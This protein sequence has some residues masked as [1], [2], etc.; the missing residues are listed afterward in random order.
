[1]QYREY[2]ETYLKEVAEISQ[3]VDRQ[4]IHNAIKL[5]KDLKEK[6]GRLFFLGI[7][8]SAANSSHA[9]NDFRKICKI[10]T[11]TPVD[12]VAELTAWTNDH[13]FEV[14]FSHWLQGSR[15]TKND[16]VMVFSVGGGSEKTSRNIVRALEYAKKVGSKIIGVVSKD[17]GMTKQLADV[18]ILIPVVHDKRITAH[19][20]EWQGVVWHLIVNALDEYHPS[21]P[22][23]DTKTT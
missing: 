12:N 21:D 4:A 15:L 1:M 8:G 14:I 3:K 9:V 18:V 22:Y 19:A 16:V 7:G 13:S 5:L 17:G 2:I 10:E 23:G 6:S 11:Y 20:E